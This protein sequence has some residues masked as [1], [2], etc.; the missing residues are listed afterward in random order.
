MD[1]HT[2]RLAKTKAIGKKAAAAASAV[3]LAA[4]AAPVTPLLQTLAPQVARA[5]G[6]ELEVQDD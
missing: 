5:E 3:V 1:Y 6:A 4:S 2:K